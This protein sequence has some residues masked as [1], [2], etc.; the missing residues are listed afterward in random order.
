MFHAG[1]ELYSGKWLADFQSLDKCL[2]TGVLQCRGLLRAGNHSAEHFSCTVLRLTLLLPK[3]SYVR[4]GRQGS[5]HG[6][7]ASRSFRWAR[8]TA[9]TANC[10][11]PSVPKRWH[12]S[13][14]PSRVGSLMSSR[15]RL[16]ETAWSRFSLGMPMGNWVQ[17]DLI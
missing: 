1:E 12:G 7:S 15:E 5:R 4:L 16:R 17:R 9:A 10:C 3:V 2:A 8:C 14:V 11:R 6:T 13:R